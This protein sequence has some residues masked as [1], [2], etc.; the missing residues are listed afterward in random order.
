[1]SDSE[2]WYCLKHKTVE[3]HDGCRNAD[4]LGPYASEAEAARALDRVA[5]RNEEWDNDPQ[6]NEDGP[7][8][9]DG[10]ADGTPDN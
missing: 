7:S 3:G 9:G 8:S 1:M 2:Y 4:R 6:W 10:L 5:E